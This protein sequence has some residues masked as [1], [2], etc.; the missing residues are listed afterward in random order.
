[1][2]VNGMVYGSCMDAQHT[3]ELSGTEVG[4]VA[5]R[6]KRANVKPNETPVPFGSSAGAT[7]FCSVGENAG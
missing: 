1:M 6:I 4:S 7:L 3:T 5:S 2:R